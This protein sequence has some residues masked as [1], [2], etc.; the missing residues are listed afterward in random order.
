[1]HLKQLKTLVQ[2]SSNRHKMQMTKVQLLVKPMYLSILL[3]AFLQINNGNKLEGTI[4][5][6][7]KE[8]KEH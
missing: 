8:F 7:V 2:W 4:L 6:V 1:M 3:N 5:T